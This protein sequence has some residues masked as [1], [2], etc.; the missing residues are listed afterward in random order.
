MD[1]E[2]NSCHM[3]PEKSQVGLIYNHLGGYC[4]G[5][6]VCWSLQRQEEVVKFTKWVMD[7]LK[8]LI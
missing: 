2:L 7:H 6:S 1:T 4:T 3:I 5:Q 8:S